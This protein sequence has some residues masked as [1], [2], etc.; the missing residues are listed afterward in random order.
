M[1]NSKVYIYCDPRFDSDY[2]IR[3]GKVLVDLNYKP[4]YVGCAKYHNHLRW[5]YG[6][7]RNRFVKLRIKIIKRNGFTPI[8]KVVKEFENKK[9]ALKLEEELIVKIGRIDL[10]TGP[11]L[12]RSD[13]PGSKNVNKDESIA[14]SKRM[15]IRAKRMNQGKDHPLYGKRHSKETKNKISKSQR[16][17]L[18]DKKIRKIMSLAQT[19][20]NSHRTKLTED[21]VLEIRKLRKEGFTI[22][23]IASKFDVGEKCVS[24]IVNRNSWR[25]I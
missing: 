2:K 15:S 14:R 7:G 16:R 6:N 4:F 18:T 11:L 3:C 21:D 12:N 17:R 22:K 19:G 5:M 20:E 23:T 24:H 9:E 1:R 10:G 13:G 8:L 25:H